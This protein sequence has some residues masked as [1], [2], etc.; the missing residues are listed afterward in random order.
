MKEINSFRGDYRFLSNFSPSIV[1]FEGHYY[2]SVEHA[3]QAAKTTSAFWRRKIRLAPKPGDAK[4][5]G[6]ELT[7][8][9]EWDSMKDLVMLQLLRHK[10]CDRELAQ[11]LVNTHPKILVEGNTWGD[12]YWGVCTKKG[13]NRLGAILMQIRSELMSDVMVKV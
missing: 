3:Y 13:Q 1:Y 7:L 12:D 8:C 10:F 6:G 11:A 9:E 2:P 4:R 5:I